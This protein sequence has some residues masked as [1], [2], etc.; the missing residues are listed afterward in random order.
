MPIQ[1]F[2]IDIVPSFNSSNGQGLISANLSNE[3]LYSSLFLSLSSI[4]M[5]IAICSSSIL[6]NL[7]RNNSS[8]PSTGPIEIA[9]STQRSLENQLARS[10]ENL[11]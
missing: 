3:N 4:A 5:G 2:N 8:T 1:N 9:M 10:Q 11:V 6:K 7:F